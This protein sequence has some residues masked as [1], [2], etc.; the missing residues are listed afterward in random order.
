VR[1]HHAGSATVLAGTTEM[2]Q[3]S[4]TVF[5]QI[6]A[7]SLGIPFDRISVVSGDTGRAP[8]DAVTASSRSTVCMGNAITAACDEVRKKLASLTAEVHGV[9]PED[10]AVADGQVRFPGGCQTYGN[11][12]GACYGRGEGEV[13]GVGEFRLPRD[14]DHPL[15]GPAPFWEIIFV[16]AEVEVDE[17][18][19][20]YTVTK[21]ATAA[22]VGKAINPAQVK[23]QD[24]GGALMSVGQAQMEQLILDERGVPRNL[25]ALDY[26]IPTT[27][28]T[29]LEVTSL[30]MENADGPGPFGAKGVGESGAI[31]VAPAICSAVSQATGASFTELPITAER[32]WRALRERDGAAGH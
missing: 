25:G 20:Q 32:V 21:L 24:E 19:G 18:T 9:S 15:G 30:L 22:D 29:P 3:G 13:I 4:Q 17:E 23:G 2:G 31:A 28:D 5:A 11:A 6:A 16:A 27:M 14:A 1:L 12:I 10:V 26:R 7:Q 8:F